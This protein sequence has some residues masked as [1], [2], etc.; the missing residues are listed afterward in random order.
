MQP[1][2]AFIFSVEMNDEILTEER[3]DL[4]R[5]VYRYESKAHA[6]CAE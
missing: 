4:A 3:L 2:F 1:Y 5:N 6:S